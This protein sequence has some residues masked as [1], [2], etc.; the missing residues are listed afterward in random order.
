MDNIVDLVN[1]QEEKDR[2]ETKLNEQLLRYIYSSYQNRNFDNVDKFLDTHLESL[3]ISRTI[4]SI[5]LGVLESN[6]KFYS[7]NLDRVDMIIDNAYVTEIRDDGVKLTKVIGYLQD[8]TN[9]SI[10]SSSETNTSQ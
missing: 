4:E 3:N 9:D 5:L 1:S 2:I 7:D 10:S 6:T 8:F